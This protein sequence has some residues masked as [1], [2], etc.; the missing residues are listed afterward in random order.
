MNADAY[1]S[2]LSLVNSPLS[3]YLDF[4]AATSVPYMLQ[5]FL[6]YQAAVKITP[7]DVEVKF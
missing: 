6:V 1:K 7:N 5:L 4:N 2:G 3:V